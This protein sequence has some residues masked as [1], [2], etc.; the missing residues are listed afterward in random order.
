MI[1]TQQ[2]RIL[3]V[4]DLHVGR[5]PDRLADFDLPAEELGPA[6]ALA[7]LIEMAVRDGYHA[8]VFAGDLVDNDD[9]LFEAYG[10]L[11]G[12]AMR[13]RDAGIP[14]WVVAGNHDARVLRKLV[15]R[16]EHVRM[17]GDGG[18]WESI[19]LEGPVSVGVLGWS[20]PANRYKDDPLDAQGYAEALGAVR[21]GRAVL[22]VLHCDL[23][24]GQSVY[25]P[26]SGARLRSTGLDAWFLGHIHVP[27]ALE[28]PPHIGYLGSV[29]GLDRGESGPRGP[30]HVGVSP[31]GTLDVR[32]RSVGPVLWRELDVDLS[33]MEV[34]EDVEGW[35]SSAVLDVFRSA[36]AELVDPESAWDVVAATVR[37]TGAV[38]SRE[39]IAG[40]VEGSRRRKFS[41]TVGRRQWCMVRV[42]DA[43]H[44]VV[45]LEPIAERDTALGESARIA[46]A[47]KAPG[48]LPPE[49]LRRLEALRDE[50][51]RGKWALDP[52]RWPLDS[53]AD[54]GAGAA[55]SV[56]DKLLAQ[57]PEN[58]EA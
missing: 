24:S 3:F 47:F 29:V 12:A 14:M 44:P 20:F 35:I 38:A 57:Q 26:T 34:G 23:D 46:L 18:R 25:A 4:G 58:G 30:W 1:D 49:L 55:R 27:S 22:G 53:E 41:T 17:I 16:V 43:T 50:F 37:L 31:D 32:Q 42:H 19:V 56:F 28:Q 15:S 51:S 5:V 8:V 52:E 9:D 48:T 36:D 10:A 45:D 7:L 11:E 21:Q 2:T 33:A 13:L 6:T 40:F 39:H 54:V